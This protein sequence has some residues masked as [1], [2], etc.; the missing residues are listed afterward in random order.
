MPVRSRRLQRRSL[1]TYAFVMNG[2]ALRFTLG[3]LG[4]SY[5]IQE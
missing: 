3:S 4:R 1:V 2:N 5:A